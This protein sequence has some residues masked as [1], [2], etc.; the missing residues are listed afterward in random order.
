MT[1]QIHFWL[2]LLFS[3]TIFAQRSAVLNKETTKGE[4]IFKDAQKAIGSN[5]INLQSFSL[6]MKNVSL[7][8]SNEILIEV[9]AVLPD[10]FSE[11]TN[12]TQ[13]TQMTATSTWNGTKY[14]AIVDAVML[15]QRSVADIT[16]SSLNSSLNSEL[17]DK[18]GNKIGKE[19]AEQLKRYRK[20][21]PKEQFYLNNIWQGLFPLTL[22]QP[23]E[24]NLEYKY[25]GKAKSG[26]QVANVVDVTS[27]SGTAYRLLFDSETNYLLMMMESHEGQSM[28]GVDGTYETKLYFSN[29]KKIDNVLIPTQ[30]KIEYKFIPKTDKEPKISYEIIDILE[31]KLNPEFKKDMFEIK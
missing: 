16:K 29:R 22:I 3:T 20:K 18:I 5:E 1:K 10:K 8:T 14:K 13:P 27:P 25:I 17:V 4:Q 24:Q 26:S 31:F 19:K 11:I 30:I 21:D 2:I 7:R 23:F 9:K 12:M 6:K 15:G 28:S